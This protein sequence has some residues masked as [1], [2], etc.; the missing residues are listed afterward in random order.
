MQSF[1]HLPEILS[2]TAF[3]FESICR[4][5]AGYAYLGNNKALCRIL[6]RYKIFVDTRDVGITPHLVMDGFWETWLTQCLAKIVKP[7]DTCMDIGA[8][9]GYY[10]IL[11]SIL[12]GKKGRTVAVEPNPAVYSLLRETA[13]VHSA[14]IETIDVAL[15]NSSGRA[16]LSI[17]ENYFGDASLVDRHDKNHIRRSKVKV[18][19]QTL[20]EMAREMLLP[21]IDVIKMDVEGVEP[22]VFAGMTETIAKNPGL[23][24]LVEYSPFLYS[25]PKYF[26][27]YLF[28]HFTVHRIKD[29]DEMITLS[30]ADIPSLIS[31]TDHTDLYLIKK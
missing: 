21:K 28:Y 15:S 23:R 13:S 18:K 4:T 8:N 3:E 25:D 22:L 27:E 26:T 14:K 5:N 10:S 20:D 19:M 6:G 16:T 31:L 11:M 29:V 17:P 30:E 2:L 12:A 7:G 24:I 9:F 1:L